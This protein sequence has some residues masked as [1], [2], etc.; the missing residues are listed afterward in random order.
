[1]GLG[2][3][4]L[5]CLATSFGGP[6]CFGRGARTPTIRASPGNCS[7][8]DNQMRCSAGEAEHQSVLPYGAEVPTRIPGDRVGNYGRMPVSASVKVALIPKAR[9]RWFSTDAVRG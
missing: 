1:M 2:I 7:R 3:T 5:L 6:D 9:K 4:V 8:S